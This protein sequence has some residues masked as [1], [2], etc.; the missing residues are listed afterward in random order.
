MVIMSWIQEAVLSA[1]QLKQFEEQGYLVVPNFVSADTADQ[2]R[3]DCHKLVEKV[4]I[5]SHRHVFS[6][7]EDQGEKKDDYFLSSVDK[8]RY[9]F[10]ESAFDD[11]GELKVSR[12]ESIN[13]MAHALHRHCPGFR[14]VTFSNKC[15]SLIREF[16]FQAP[17]V[18]QS[19]YIF[20][21]PNIG[22]KVTPHQDATFLWSEPNRRLLGFWVA[23]EDVTEENAC[24][25]FVPGSHKDGLR[26][27]RRWARNPNPEEAAKKP[28]LFTGAL[29]NIDENEY[30]PV[31][32][33]KGSLI[34]IDGYVMHLSQ[35][36]L[37]KQSR[38]VYAWHVADIPAGEVTWSP[39]S[40]LQ[41]IGG[42]F[43]DV[44]DTNAIAST[45]AE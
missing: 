1:E 39:Q 28:L 17:K 4:D 40:W 7:S 11:K 30:I 21:P 19:M 34:L 25:R 35:A 44:Y 3:A 10:E 16:G 12:F 41:P 5:S 23:L 29:P 43:W 31:P 18:V 20:K 32:V 36:N 45:A 15:K 14:S 22:G 33:A 6:C 8:L 2:L 9:F 42:D 24:L 38:H 26:N 27:G 13:K 37:S